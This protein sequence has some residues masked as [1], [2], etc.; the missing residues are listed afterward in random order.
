VSGG[1]TRPIRGV[2]NRVLGRGELNNA[3]LPEKLIL[4][5]QTMTSKYSTVHL[6]EIFQIF[7]AHILN[8]CRQVVLDVS[9]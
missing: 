1:A 7:C 4:Y 6:R 5:K 9:K 3:A 2:V 8:R